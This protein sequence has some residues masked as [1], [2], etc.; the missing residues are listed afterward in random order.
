MRMDWMIN[1]N[2]GFA[3]L[4][5]GR[6]MEV[7]IRQTDDPL[8]QIVNRK[9][10]TFGFSKI[11]SG[12]NY[13]AYIRYI[14]DPLFDKILKN[15]KLLAELGSSLGDTFNEYSWSDARREDMIN[16]LGKYPKQQELADYLSV[17]KATVSKYPKDKKE[18]ML[19]G[20]WVKKVLNNF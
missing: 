9:K 3:Q 17:N 20:L 10:I 7:I 14:S 1:Y 4:N 8:A 5:D 15:P 6:T 2:F 19:L 16:F 13:Q 12:R 11:E 18:L